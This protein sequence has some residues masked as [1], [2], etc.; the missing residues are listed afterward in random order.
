MKLV[1]EG[2]SRNGHLSL[3][4]V[5][6]SLHDDGTPTSFVERVD[7]YDRKGKLALIDHLI[8][9]LRK[10]EKQKIGCCH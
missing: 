8:D 2:F 6:K 10:A 7:L 3:K 1:G 4:G 5:V 9:D